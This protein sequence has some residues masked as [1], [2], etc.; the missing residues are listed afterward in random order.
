MSLPRP[1]DLAAHSAAMRA[2]PLHD[3]K[4]VGAPY[5]MG[6]WHKDRASLQGYKFEARI[7]A[8]SLFKQHRPRRFLILGRPR[9]GTTLLNRLLNQVEGLRCEGEVLHHA[10]LRPHGFLNRLA[11]AR[12]VQ[13]YGAKMITYQML[14]V[15]KIADP[16]VF[17]DA[18]VADGWQLIHLRRGTF[19]QSLSL[20]Q[21]QAR[22]QY[23]IR[24][25]HN[26]GQGQGAQAPQEI[27]IDPA[28]F[29]HQI[30]WNEATLAYEKALLAPFDPLV[31]D[32]ERDLADAAQH[33]PT[34]DRICAAMGIASGPVEADLARTGKSQKV[35]NME[36]LRAAVAQAGYARLL[37]PAGTG[38]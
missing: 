6:R 23:H 15:Q 19:A 14:E 24:K 36:A 9:S 31:V 26:A 7:F 28:Q 37:P 30:E 18:L 22:G 29:L 4:P 20:S 13:V 38:A 32:Y 10:V 3:I 5:V 1:A 33:Q 34:I 11:R 21:A 35:A 12:P 2:H 17:V 16:A 25:G 27:E 8:K